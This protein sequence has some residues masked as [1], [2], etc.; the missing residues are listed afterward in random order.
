M[1]KQV[2]TNGAIGKSRERR[3]CAVDVQQG[4]ADACVH[5][6]V[7][8]WRLSTHPK[9]EMSAYR[10]WP[11]SARLAP[12]MQLQLIIFQKVFKWQKLVEEQAQ[13][14]GVALR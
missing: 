3:A 11:A 13:L 9:R 10:H 6:W 4:E 14:R 1:E 12:G 5:M 7:Q 8:R 2:K